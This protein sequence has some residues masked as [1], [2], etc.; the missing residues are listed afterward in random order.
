M[1]GWQELRGRAKKGVS[2]RKTAVNSK[3]GKSSLLKKDKTPASSGALTLTL[4][5]VAAVC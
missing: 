3:S 4:F 1:A 5:R 2:T